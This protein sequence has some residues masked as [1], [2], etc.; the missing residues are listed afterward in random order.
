MNKTISQ[1][2]SQEYLLKHIDLSV[3]KI[4]IDLEIVT[5]LLTIL[6]VAGQSLKYLSSYDKAFGLIPLV[7]MAKALSIPTIFTVLIAFIATVLLGII[8][9][10]KYSQKDRY[11]GQWVGLTLFFLLTALD[12]GSALGTYFFKQFRGVMQTFNPAFPNQKWVTTFVMLLI[13]LIIFYPKFIA[14]LPKKTK[15]MSL[16]SLAVYYAGFLFVERFADQYAVLY[17]IDN[18]P[19]HILFSIGKMLEISG[20]ILWITVL[21]DYLGSCFPEISYSFIK[22]KKNK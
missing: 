4:V 16:L 2:R 10:I 15:L 19:Y 13:L 18:L 20:L 6:G 21:L 9:A 5:I 11:R 7:N 22:T 17:T 14:A 12:K 3:N 1:D 8:T